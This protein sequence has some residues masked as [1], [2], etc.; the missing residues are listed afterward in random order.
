MHDTV[1]KNASAVALQLDRR[2]AGRRGIG[3]HDIQRSFHT[4]ALGL[5]GGGERQDAGGGEKRNKYP[6]HDNYPF[7]ELNAL[8]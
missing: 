8:F 2:R 4:I 6:A 1:R 5:R 3:L 7:R